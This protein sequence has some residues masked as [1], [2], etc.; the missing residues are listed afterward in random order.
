MGGLAYDAEGRLRL[1]PEMTKADFAN[2][3][4]SR[5]DRLVFAEDP[6]TGQ[7]QVV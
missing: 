4:S 5:R 3:Y 1:I 2:L 6:V 7:E